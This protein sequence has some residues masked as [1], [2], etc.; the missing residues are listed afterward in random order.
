MASGPHLLNSWQ[1]LH[2]AGVL[3]Q[4][5]AAAHDEKRNHDEKTGSRNDSDKCDVV[6]GVLLSEARDRSNDLGL[7]RNIPRMP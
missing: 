4:L 7:K 3:I 5:F 6:H 1:A 2:V